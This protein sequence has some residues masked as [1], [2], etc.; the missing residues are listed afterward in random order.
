[1]VNTEVQKFNKAKHLAKHGL[2]CL[3][4]IGGQLICVTNFFVYKDPGIILRKFF[5][6]VAV[7]TSLFFSAYF[8]CLQASGE[9]WKKNLFA[10]VF[11]PDFFQLHA[12]RISAYKKVPN[13]AFT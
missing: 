4:A 9:N 12:K 6:P 13:S 5:V 8:F 10:T 1:M 11:E 7:W 3:R 2:S